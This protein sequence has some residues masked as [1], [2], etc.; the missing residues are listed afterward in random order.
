MARSIYSGK[1][2]NRSNRLKLPIRK[3]PYKQL[4]APGVF[5]CYRRNGGP[6]TWSVEAGWL[7]RFA[8]A[9]DYEDAN[10]T[11][12]M[13]FYQAQ[14]HALKMV[15]GSEGDGDK[16][17]T[18]AEAVNA[19]ETD[20]EV[21][22]GAKY[23]ATSVRNHLSPTMLAKV[24]M[25]LT[26]S[27]L[28]SWRNG[29][30]AKG[31]K[32][33]SANRV[34]KSF[35]AA[36]ALAAKRD[37]RITNSAAWK[38]GLRPL[39]KKGNNN[40]PRDNYYLPDATIHVIVRECYVD[41]AEFGALIDVLAGTGTR[42]S[43]A[44][45]LWPDDIRDDDTDEPRLM[46]WC[47]SKG[48]DRD[49]EQRSLPISPKLAEM[50]RARANKRGPDRPLFDR[51]WN[52]SARFRLVLER[53][54]LHPSLTPYVLRHSSIIRQIRSNTPLRITA[55]MHDTSTTEIERTYARYLNSASDDARKGLLADAVTPAASNV[56]KL[57]R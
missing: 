48:R 25:L 12:V 41:D 57:A 8:I 28:A 55:F 22:G 47:S 42:E 36:L 31:L 33:S 29:L 26:E 54:N 19:Y 6:G 32:L 3:K 14:A 56:V 27:E 21:R 43:Q 44:L 34:G 40:P 49:A 35:K 2:K 5:Q 53:L 45:K 11:S 51:I 10:G 9:D 4:I 52:M 16:P 23:N 18:A 38:N 39:K 37:K 50:L 46:M 30:V 17:A 13:S 15:R 1:L 24:V 7:K 20:L